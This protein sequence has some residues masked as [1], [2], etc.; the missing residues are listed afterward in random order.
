MTGWIWRTAFD[1][2]NFVKVRTTPPT[3][4]NF[5]KNPFSSVLV[6]VAKIFVGLVRTT[7]IYSLR[8]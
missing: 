2:G 6:P 7:K 3:K 1:A 5:S 4:I 8:R